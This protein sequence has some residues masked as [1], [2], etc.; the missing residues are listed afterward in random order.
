MTDS[1]AGYDEYKSDSALSERY[2]AF[3]TACFEQGIRAVVGSTPVTAALDVAC[4]SGDSTAVLAKYAE[5]V[6]AVDLS[7]ALIAKA[8]ARPELKAVELHQGDFLEYPLA[9]RYDLITAAWLHNFLH[10]EQDQRR[11]LHKLAGALNE[12]GAV[13]LLFP[14]ETFTSSRTGRYV[15]RLTWHQAW[16]EHTARFT[17]GVFSFRDAPWQVMTCWQPLY[18]FELYSKRFDLQFLDTKKLCVEGGFLDE[19]YLSPPFE[20]M[21]GRKRGS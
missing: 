9:R 21:Y 8:Q 11:A 15:A 10:N 18:L 17:R 7:P 6:E 5:H 13:V 1:W 20:V 14:S 4:G 3:V 2:Y 12:G 16:Y 19:Q